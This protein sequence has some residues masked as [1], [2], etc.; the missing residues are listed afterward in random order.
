MS[1]GRCR[2]CRSN[3]LSPV[4]S[5]GEM[6]LANALV[7]ADEL[8]RAEPRFPLDAVFCAACALF[9]ISQTL[10]PDALFR[11]YR[12][13]S[14]C[15]E[16]FVA[17]TRALCDRLIAQEQLATDSLV[18]EIASNDVYLLQ[19]YVR[20]GIPVLGVEPARAI[21]AL[22]E[23]RGVRTVPEFFGPGLA[24]D[25]VHQVGHADVVHA[26]NVLAHVPDVNGVVAGIREL[27]VDGGIAVIEVPYLRDM[28]DRVEFDT[29]YHEHLCYFSLIALDTLVRR[30]DLA[31]IDVEQVAIHGGTLQVSLA[32]GTR[33]RHIA[34]SVHEV[35]YAERRLG[36]DRRSYYDD[37]AAN[38]DR[39]RTGLRAVVNELKADD[40]RIAGYGASAK[41]TTLLHY[42][43]IGAETLDFIVDRNPLKQGRFTPGSHIPIYGPDRLIQDQPDYA[44]LLVWNLA[45]EV[46]RQQSEYRGRGGRFIVP[47][48]STTIV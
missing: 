2:S 3:A 34:A 25:L 28:I 6:P 21:A 26:H 38:V 20:K 46:L 7:C 30:H 16:T 5:L 8:D 24:R 33:A 42:C 18:V 41:G 32:H 13:L 11:D 23:A 43:G 40:C 17:H 45:D 9:Q 44:L 39:Y 19:H 47:A 48:L 27:L 35:L 15:S 10:P 37:F 1:D 36:M 22:A 14:S 29:I 4:L 12:Y 31:I